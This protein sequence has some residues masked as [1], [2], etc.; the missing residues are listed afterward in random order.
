MKLQEIEKIID[1]IIRE[2]ESRTPCFRYKQIGIDELN[3]MIEIL[4]KEKLKLKSSQ[5][6][7]S[8]EMINSVGWEM[9]E[10]KKSNRCAAFDET[11]KCIVVPISRNNKEWIFEA[12]KWVEQ[13]CII[14]EKSF[15][16]YYD[17]LKTSDYIYID[18]QEYNIMK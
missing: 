8:S 14:H 6:T 16:I 15:P 18:V 1:L 17:Y 13:F 11:N 4:S 9:E 7:N 10:M 12:Y 2:K 5:T 3:D